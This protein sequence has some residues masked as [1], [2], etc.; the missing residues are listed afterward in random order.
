MAKKETPYK[1]LGAYLDE[2]LKDYN[3]MVNPKNASGE[4]VKGGGP[5]SRC[6]RLNLINK[7]NDTSQTLK[8]N[9][10]N[11]VK[12]VF[13][14]PEKVK[15]NQLSPN[16]S[17]FSSVSF[18]FDGYSYDLIIAK[19]ANKGEKFETKTIEQLKKAFNIVN[20]DGDRIS[21]DLE[22]YYQLIAML[23]EENSKFRPLD[24]KSVDKNRKPT[25]KENIPIADLGAIIGD[26]VLEDTA[27]NSWYISVKNIDGDTFSSYSGAASL[28]NKKGELQENSK[29]AD[30][31][32]SFGVDLNEVQAGFDLR[33]NIKVKRPRFKY[34][35]P[36][37]QELKAIFERAWGMNY[38]YVRKLRT[39]WQVKWIDR[40]Y[41]NKLVNGIEVDVKNISYPNLS[42]K[43][44]TIKCGTGEKSY[45]VEMRHSS[46]G[47]YPN[48]IKFKV[49]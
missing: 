9:L 43:Q 26:V 10:E 29:G 41:L 35:K 6:Y 49:R 34:Q 16:S 30:F 42:R 15:F 1:D 39:G 36:N 20:S 21:V 24:V 46:G 32:R 31:L 11:I 28:F 14:D 47:E 27:G 48:D 8:E 2:Y 38:F 44:I 18:D 5:N 37:T 40:K 17:K 25:K 7:N 13:P 45:T 33:N 4:T 22:D 19:G 12:S 23:S 3:F